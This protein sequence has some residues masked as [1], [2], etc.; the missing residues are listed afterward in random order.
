MAGGE[1]AGLINGPDGEC[2]VLG[3]YS[4][5]QVEPGH[6]V[7]GLDVAGVF[8]DGLAGEAVRVAGHR[9]GGAD[10]GVGVARDAGVS[11]H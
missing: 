6:A 8:A 11:W 5:W 1:V 9:N 2:V 3:L 4:R 7:G 10:P